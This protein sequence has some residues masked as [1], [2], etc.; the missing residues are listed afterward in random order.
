[1]LDIRVKDMYKA[2]TETLESLH[3]N[4]TDLRGQSYD[5]AVNMS[6]TYKGLQAFIEK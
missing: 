6:G 3:I 5:N 1:M 2:P 4:I